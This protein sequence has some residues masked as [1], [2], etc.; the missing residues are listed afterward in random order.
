MLALQASEKLGVAEKDIVCG[1]NY[2]AEEKRNFQVDRL[3]YKILDM[4]LHRAQD[5][6]RSDRPLMPSVDELM[7]GTI[8]L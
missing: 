4:A 8:D 7:S 3:T 6:C 5:L 1:Y 2:T